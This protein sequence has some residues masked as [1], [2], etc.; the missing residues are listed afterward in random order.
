MKRLIKF[1]AIIAFVLS[2]SNSKSE[3][4]TNHHD[5]SIEKSYE[6]HHHNQQEELGA[7]EPT[8]YSIYNSQATWLTQDGKE[9]KLND[10]KGRIQVIAMA[11]TSCQNSCPRIVAD[12]KRIESEVVKSHG[13]KVG[14]VLV[15]IDPERDTPEKLKAFAAERGLNLE[16]WTL[17]HGNENDILELA[18]L[19]GV[20]YKK[21]SET[22]YAHSNVITV[23]NQHGEVVHQ[24]IGLGVNH[25]ETMVTINKLIK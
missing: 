14:L 13:D 22:D 8:D 21:L 12:M 19:L 20:K 3:N 23:L 16:H 24:Q 11:Y 18:A 5:S 17:L 4:E 9:I 15:S 6:H 2:A 1:I 7:K 10:L 25:L